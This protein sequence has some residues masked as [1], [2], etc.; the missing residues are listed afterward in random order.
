MTNEEAQI[1][2]GNIPIKPE[3][4]DD[5]YD[6]TEYQTAKAMAIKALEQQPCEDAVS[7][8]RVIILI[9]EASEIHPYKVVG[10]SNTYSNY[11]QGWS[12][13]CDW[14]YANIE[15][16]PS[17]TSKIEPC[18][19]CISRQ[20]VKRKLQEHHDLF[21]NAYGGRVGFKS[22]ADAK[23]KA[24]VDEI[25]NCIAMVVNEPSVTPKEKTG[26]IPVSE[27]LPEESKRY[28]VA[29]KYNDVMTD[30]YTGER[31][32]QGDDVIAW[33][34]LPEPYEPQESEEI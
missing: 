4:L 6:V 13:A 31:F 33:M 21:I 5:C 19:D 11:N 32:L 34:P 22:M 25:T 23:E 20:A 9:D 15:G 18:E 28:V 1:I 24:R 29:T 14:L 30:F 12:D 10:D 3:V 8:K 17:V 2:I 26:W 16:I 7:R 27:R